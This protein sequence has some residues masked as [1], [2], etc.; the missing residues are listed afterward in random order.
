[1]SPLVN[2]CSV[3]DTKFVITSLGIERSEVRRGILLIL[4]KAFEENALIEFVPELL[5]VTYLGPNPDAL[6]AAGS[7]GADDN[8]TTGSSTL[9]AVLFSVC[10]VV[11]LLQLIICAAGRT[12]AFKKARS[13]CCRKHNDDLARSE[14]RSLPISNQPISKRYEIRYSDREMLR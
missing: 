7:T 4:T 11:L 6:V 10:C 13:L 1:M 5:M 14:Q 9:L 12:N 2:S 8:S 3:L